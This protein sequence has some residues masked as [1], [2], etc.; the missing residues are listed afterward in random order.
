MADQISSEEHQVALLNLRSRSARLTYALQNF[1]DILKAHRRKT[2]P[3]T[4]GGGNQFSG[5][6]YLEGIDLEW[7]A[8]HLAQN[9]YS[10]KKATSQIFRMAEQ[11][12]HL[13]KRIDLDHSEKWHLGRALMSGFTLAGIYRIEQVD[14]NG[15][16]PHY[17]I[18]NDSSISSDP[19]E[20]TRE[21][22]FPLWKSNWDEFGNRLVSPSYPCP[23]DLI[24]EPNFNADSVWLKAVHKLENTAFRINEEVLEW[25]ENEKVNQKIVPP[26][27]DNYDDDRA[28]LDKHKKKIESLRKKI[29]VYKVTTDDEK[30]TYKATI[31]RDGKYVVSRSFKAKKAANEWAK[32]KKDQ[33]N[34]KIPAHEMQFWNKWHS[35]SH[36]LEKKRIRF[37]SRRNQFESYLKEARRWVG[38]RF[39]Q[40]VSMD[41]RGRLY[42]PPFSYQGS[43]FCRAVIEFADGAP[44]TE[45]GV[46]SLARH[47]ANVMGKN[48]SPEDLM[49]AG[50]AESN[51]LSF[52]VHQEF[53]TTAKVINK[54]RDSKK[55]FGL[56]R[57]AL[58]WR[59]YYVFLAMEKL[60]RKKIPLKDLSSYEEMYEALEF[61]TVNKKRHLLSY[62]PI[63]A[64]HRNSAFQHIGMMMNNADGNDLVERCRTEDL[65]QDIAEKSGL[66]KK[67]AR[68]L[69]KLISVPWSYGSKEYS[70][71]KKVLDYRMQNAG[72]IK[73]LDDLDYDGVEELVSNI[74]KLLNK[75]FKACADYQN[76]IIKH[77][78]GIKK[79][80]PKKSDE[81]IY[82]RSFSD[83]WVYQQVFRAETK[84]GY[85]WDGNG[86]MPQLN[87][88]IPQRELNW[89][90]MK[91]KT[92]PNLV[93]SVDASVAHFVLALDDG[94]FSFNRLIP[95]HDSFSVPVDD[96]HDA[97]YK[98]QQ[99]TDL[100]YCYPPIE[101]FFSDSTGTPRID[102]EPRVDFPK[103]TTYS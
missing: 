95:I 98:F 96:A 42:L 99:V 16:A 93:H 76:K 53:R 57:T 56:F 8:T 90:N 103:R 39:Y 85:V 59:N 29:N 54:F 74:Y 84:H 28:N 49:T 73:I 77:V 63:A 27:P 1:K 58:E 32:N 46:A 69:I 34:A 66:P 68:A 19:T 61:K 92:P 10:G 35:D 50:S 3:N 70:C 52:L 12:C 81:G 101:N 86:G 78:E 44:M 4:R 40:R 21:E 91:S 48:A 9:D 88:L 71:R 87:V 55:P 67:D 79:S 80:R 5:L 75:E 65:Y 22:P 97:L 43:D 47:T 45:S 41:Y 36:V 25:A 14:D 102:E 37:E 38:K 83:F 15:D 31:Y 2:N 20:R 60:G 17:V 7:L 89:R 72:E 82:W 100:M 11:A 6:K 26:L 24:Y 18:A 94:E 51:E 33:L 64:D 23:T 30:K 13:L 62:L